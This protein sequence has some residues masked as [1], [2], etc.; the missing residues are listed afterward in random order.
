MAQNEYPKLRNG[1]EALSVEHSG[2]RMLL[3]RDKVGYARD[4]LL[5]SPQIVPILAKMNGGSSLRDLQ[6][7][8]MRDTGQLLYLEELQNLVNTLDEYL[9]L[10]NDRFRGLEATE[11]AAFLDNSLRKPYHAGQ[12]YPDNPEELRIMLDLFFSPEQGGPGL[13]DS[14]SAD[15]GK[16]LVGLVAPHIDLNAGGG[17]FAH[18]YKAAAEAEQPETWIILGTGHDLVENCFALTVKD[19]ET[20][21]GIVRCNREIC[22]KLL[23]RTPAN[24]RAS[25]YNHRTEHTI[26]FQAVFLSFMQPR[27][28]I[29]PVLCS[30]GHEEWDSCKDFIDKF[31]HTLSELTFNENHSI[32]ILA[33]VDLAHV[34][35]RYGDA[36]APH[37]G[38]VQDNISSDASLLE[39]LEECR[40]GE[41]ISRIN[42]DGNS[43][44]ICGVA[45]LYT[46]AKAL[47]GHA[48]GKTLSHTHAVVDR[49]NSFVTFASMAFYEAL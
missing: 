30:F 33:S 47:E 24:I 38:T 6:A 13:P 10:D 22:E 45:P 19:F 21:L 23:A 20:P 43:R 28:R 34:G 46:M 9:F 35:P 15:S 25:E 26:E 2:Q 36:S 48:R 1:L 18:A 39:L 11:I 37:R 41:F 17:C 49:E 31:A 8:F 44:K 14:S 16:K 27:A 5:F 29:V 12:S 42:R 40:A 32:G 3:L 4:P 7:E